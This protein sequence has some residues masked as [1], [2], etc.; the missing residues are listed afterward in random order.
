MKRPLIILFLIALCYSSPSFSQDR[1]NELRQQAQESLDKKEYIRARY[2]FL[3]AY[4]AYASQKRYDKAVECGIN[5]SALYHRENYYKEAFETLYNTEIF[6]AEGEKNSRK[7]MPALRFGISKERLRMYIKLKNSARAKEQL[8]RL[9]ELAGEAKNDSLDNDL[10]YTQATYYYTFG[11]NTQGDDAINRLTGKYK[12]R[13]DYGKVDE[14]YKNLIGIARQANNAALV[15]RTY[16]RYLLWNDSV[17]ALVAQEKL[18]ALQQKYDESLETIR[19][20]DESLGT[21]QYI[22]VGLCALAA[23]LA[24]ALVLGAVVLLRYVLLTRK[25]K[26]AVATAN[27]HNRLKTGFIRNISVQMEPTLDPNEPGVQALRAFSAH[28]QE[29]SELENRSEPYELEEKN[30]SAFCEGVMDKVR[31]KTRE[32]VTLTVNAP[33]LNVKISPAQ[34]ERIL[35]HL[36]ENAAGHTPEG[37]KIWLDFKKR[38][39]HTHQFIVSDTGCGVPEELR[40]N[41]FKPFTGVKVLTEGDGLGLPICSLIAARMNGSLTLDETYTKGARFIL[42]LHA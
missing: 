36:L 2:L 28:I 29:L 38:G 41:L 4:N 42:E 13:K 32:D 17:N 12:E 10:L 26:K 24:A 21:K 5:V 3:Q 15:A 31:G 14:C 8:N 11:M 16:D 40:E 30:V 20:K 23:I 9:T 39:A 1:G 6:L 35:L 33:K 22:I 37:G 27:E 19:Q 34:L 18:D 7:P 25:Q